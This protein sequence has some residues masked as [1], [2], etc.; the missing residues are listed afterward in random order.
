MKS[1]QID[2]EIIE[3]NRCPFYKVGEHL[4]LSDKSLCCPGNKATCLILVREMTQLLFKLLAMRSEDLIAERPIFNCSGCT[5]LIKFIPVPT[6]AIEIGEVVEVTAVLG[7][8]E[9]DLLRKIRSFPVIQA[10]PEEELFQFVTRCQDKVVREGAVLIHKGEVNSYLYL[11]IV[12][13]MLV[14]DGPVVITTLGP[15]ELCGEMSYLGGDVAGATVRALC[16]TEVVAVSSEDFNYLLDKLPSLQMFMARLLAKRLT[17]VNKA[18]TED[19]ASCMQG[20]LQDMAPAE[21]FQ[22]FHMNSKTGVLSLEL[23]RGPGKISFREGCIIN[24]HYRGHENEEAIF[25][26]LGEHE[27]TYRFTIG[28]SPNEMKAAE[29]GD[30]MKLLM[31][32]IKRVDDA[33]EEKHEV[34]AHDD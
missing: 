10:I 18:R 16:D 15:G 19:F 21:L 29:V 34:R 7:G 2:F 4:V 14:I 22:V 33:L 8:K 28:L 6:P 9:Q 3:G 13:Q 26:M 27:G 24:A 11:I 30:F 23:P 12:G 20:R 31:E 32:G 25:A 5:G 17:R 1:F